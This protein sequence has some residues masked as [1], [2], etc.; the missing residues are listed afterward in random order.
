MFVCTITDVRIGLTSSRFTVTE[1]IDT[2][3]VVCA[4]LQEGTLERNVTLF[5]ETGASNGTETTFN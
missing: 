3:I 5:V 4:E 2:A 1:S